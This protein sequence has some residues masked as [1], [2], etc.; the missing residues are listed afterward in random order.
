[1]AEYT[2]SIGE[3][4]ITVDVQCLWCGQSLEDGREETG[5]TGEGPD[6]GSKID[7][8]GHPYGT[9]L[10]YGCDYSPDN[11]D[12]ACGSHAPNVLPTWDGHLI[13]FDVEEMRYRGSL[14]N[15]YSKV[16]HLDGKQGKDHNEPVPVPAGV[17]YAA[18]YPDG[19]ED[20]D[21]VLA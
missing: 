14:S 12:E 18:D 7:N 4:K 2:F 19:I 3:K 17:R 15:Y 11:D 9:F 20:E 10:D 8:D 21:G 1:M 6:W 13:V 5:F 16:V